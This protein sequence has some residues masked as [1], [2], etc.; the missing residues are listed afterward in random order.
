VNDGKP[1]I[2]DDAANQ[3]Y[4]PDWQSGLYYEAV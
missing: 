4:N 1:Y 3:K 2:V